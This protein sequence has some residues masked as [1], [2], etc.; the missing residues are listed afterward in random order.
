MRA[1]RRDWQWSGP[2]I[3]TDK[4]PISGLYVDDTGRI[5]VRLSQPAS[6]NASV[7]HNRARGQ[8]EA[9]DILR[10]I[11]LRWREPQVFD[12]L[13]PGGAYVGRVQLPHQAIRFAVHGD[14]IWLVETDSNDVAAVR[15]YR[16]RWTP[17]PLGAG[18]RRR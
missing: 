12:V 1:V 18:A 9:W 3:P 5:W 7:I 11:R 4:P 15:Q 13:V 6:L 8:G 14:T 16:I 10:D 17:R 2:E